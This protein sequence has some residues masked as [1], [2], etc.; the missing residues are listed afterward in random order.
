MSRHFFD[1]AHA[2]AADHDR[3]GRRVEPEADGHDVWR[4]VATDGGEATEPLAREVRELGLGER[5]HARV[6]ASVGRSMAQM[7][8]P[9][10]S[11]QRTGRRPR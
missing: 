4:A 8:T 6:T 7:V 1:V 2:V 3:V 9:P 5:A 11:R 10:Q